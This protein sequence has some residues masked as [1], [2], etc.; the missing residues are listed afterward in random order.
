MTYEPKTERV[1]LGDGLY[2]VLYQETRHGTQKVVNALTRPFLSYPDGKGPKLS[3]E[4]EDQKPKVE[5]STKVEVDLK[6][7]DYDAV[8]DAII[9]GQVKEWS[10]GDV[11]QETL[12]GITED[13]RE[14]LKEECNRLY[15]T[16][17]PLA[18]G[19]VGN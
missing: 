2:A 12:D 6:A 10:F 7:I 19:G 9:I 4:G 15:G 17:G 18:E 11:T 1:D 3:L 5:V 13:L 8:N 16:K 14:K